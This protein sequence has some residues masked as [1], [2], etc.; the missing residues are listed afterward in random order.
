MLGLAPL[1]AIPLAATFAPV[2]IPVEM[3][4][5]TT[6]TF[7]LTGY[8]GAFL[9]L[10]GNTTL[11]LTP[12][13]TLFVDVHSGGTTNLSFALEGDLRLA[14]APMAFNMVPDNL[15]FRGNWRAADFQMVPS[16]LTFRGV[17]Q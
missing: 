14:G 15:Q 10:S 3:A 17:K 2:A 7:T 11:T 13:A 5:A 9:V 8:G 4:G 12:T 16:N 6:L 1:A